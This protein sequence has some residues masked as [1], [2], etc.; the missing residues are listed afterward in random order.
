M[1]EEPVGEK[2]VRLEEGLRFLRSSLKE[3]DEKVDKLDEKVDRLNDQ[4][5]KKTLGLSDKI[6]TLLRKA[7]FDEEIKKLVTKIE[8][9]P[10]KKAY[11]GMITAAF[12]AILA[13]VF[14][15]IFK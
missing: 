13:A 11:Y 3:L 6:S 15:L 5:D 7:D 8:F 4:L 2:I 12:L 10:I 14:T 9:D 1:V